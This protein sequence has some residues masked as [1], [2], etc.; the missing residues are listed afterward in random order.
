MGRIPYTE[1][2]LVS[3]PMQAGGMEYSGAAAMALGLYGAGNTASGSPNS[4]FLEFATAHEAAHQWFFNQVMNDQ[5]KEPWLDEGLA[6][7]LTYVYYLDTYGTKAADQIRAIFE[8]YWSRAGN[9][10]IPIGMPADDYDEVEYAAIIYGRAPLFILELEKRMG[11][12][13][14]SRFL[15]DYVNEYRWKTVNTQQFRITGG[16]NLRLRPD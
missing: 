14:F 6:Q 7:Y 11:E 16:G 10:P 2:D 8:G 13:V 5:I 3:T 1:Y 9:Q 15:A 4:D 12:E